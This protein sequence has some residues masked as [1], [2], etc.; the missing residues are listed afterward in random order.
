M[1]KNSFILLCMLIVLNGIWLSAESAVD[2]SG[3]VKFFTSFFVSDNPGGQ[4]FQHESGE[5]GFKRVEARLKFSGR[6]N[7]RVSYNLRF[8]AFSNSGNIISSDLFPEAGILG[9]PFYSEYFEINLYEG[10]IKISDFLIKKLDLT[11]GKQRIQWGAADK[12][13]VVDVLNPIDFANF[14]TFDPDYAYDRRPQTALNFEYYIGMASKL[15]LVW[16]FQHQVA[17]LPYGYTFFTKNFQS[18]DELTV[19]RSWENKISDTNFGLR[20]ST[21]LLNIDTALYYYQGN[22]AIP[23]LYNLTAGETINAGFLYPLLQMIGADL[24]GELWGV[25]FW[26]EAAYFIPEKVTA[27]AELPVLL[28]GT[29][30]VMEQHFDLFEKGYFKYVIGA[31]YHLGSGF[32]INAQFLHGFF[33]ESDFSSD[34]KTFFGIST[35]QFFGELESYLVSRLEYSNPA[36]TLKIGLGSL[37]EISDENSFSLFPAFEWKVADSMLIQ[38]GGFFNVSG[39]ET[40]SKFGMFRNDRVVYL[41]FKLDF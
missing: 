18:M 35:G 8:D 2:V 34:S 3:R 24:S 12:V 27:T 20:F 13:N 6:F 22:A 23:T 31:D 7:N 16:L 17:P 5:F 38:A 41:S 21:T 4:F 1:K 28:N 29:F 33:D 14:F 40:R 36:G 19:S 37:Y 30:Q 39:D 9:S 32:Y 10:T 15:Q 25:G 26:A 11:V